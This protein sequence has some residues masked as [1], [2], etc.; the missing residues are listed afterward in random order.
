MIVLG[1]L[2]AGAVAALVCLRGM[3]ATF[4]KPVLDRENF[5]D[6]HLPT[7]VGLCLVVAVLAV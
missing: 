3:A 4:A 1:L 7:A 5:R 6:A 2:V